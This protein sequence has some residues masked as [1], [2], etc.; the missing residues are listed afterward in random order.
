MAPEK[1]R[2]AGKLLNCVKLIRLLKQVI[3]SWE[4]Y[5]ERNNYGAFDHVCLIIPENRNN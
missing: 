4:L 3:T 2:Q 1:K 5:A